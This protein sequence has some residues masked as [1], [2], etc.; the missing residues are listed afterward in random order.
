MFGPAPR[1]VQGQQAL[2][3]FGVAEA[4]GPA[5]G[6]SYGGVQGSVGVG[7]PGGA[8]VV[9]VG[10]RPLFQFRALCA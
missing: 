10:Q 7:Q 6:R 1:Q 5:V 9:E 8:L 4:G 2:Q 3:D